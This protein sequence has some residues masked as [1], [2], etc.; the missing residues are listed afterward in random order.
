[1]HDEQSGSA[2]AAHSINENS[3]ALNVDI[4]KPLDNIDAR[5]VVN[6]FACR[7]RRQ[8]ATIIV[9][10]S[11]QISSSPRGRR[12]NQQA[13]PAAAEIL[14]T[15]CVYLKNKIRMYIFTIQ[16]TTIHPT[17]QEQDMEHILHASERAYI[18][19]NSLARSRSSKC[20][21]RSIFITRTPFILKTVL[22]PSR[23]V[24]KTE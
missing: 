22:R 13:A 6:L 10:S 16:I 2:A 4:G 15:R 5:R 3:C 1:M 12:Q 14:H 7:M 8:H 19:S 11:S 23:S 18:H 21:G 17:T 20:V 24:H 9:R